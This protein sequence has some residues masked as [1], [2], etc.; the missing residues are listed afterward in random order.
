MNEGPVS[1]SRER[2]SLEGLCDLA[3]AE[4]NT[5]LVSLV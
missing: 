4:A 2:W 1:H 3:A 5:G